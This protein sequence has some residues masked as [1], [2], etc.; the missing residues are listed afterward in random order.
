M[1]NI[2]PITFPANHP[3]AGFAFKGGYVITACITTYASVKDFSNNSLV[4]TAINPEEFTNSYE[5]FSMGL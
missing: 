3:T 4:K 2:V 1:T 5:S